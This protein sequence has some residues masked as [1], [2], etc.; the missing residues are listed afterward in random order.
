MDEGHG[1]NKPDKMGNRSSEEQLP[2]GVH[3]GSQNRESMLG[4]SLVREVS[5][6]KKEE[7][8]SSQMMETVQGTEGL[9]E[10]GEF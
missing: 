1:G 10:H 4:P 7:G 5:Q 8:S 3:Q 9:P 2:S 6:A